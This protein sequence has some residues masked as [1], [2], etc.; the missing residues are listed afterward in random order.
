MD[1]Q[2][3]QDDLKL[4]MT[5]CSDKEHLHAW[6][7]Y[8]LGLDF[9]DC[10]VSRFSDSNPMQFIWD[11]YDAIINGKPLGVMA[12]AGRDSFKTLGLSAIDLLAFL[13]DGRD[14]IHLAMT[15]AQGMRARSYLEEA[16]S[17][18]PA[19]QAAI[20]KQNESQLRFNIDGN[21]VGMEI[22]PCT[23]KA[24]QGGHCSLLTFDELASSMD[25]TNLRGYKDAHGIVGTSRKGQPAVVIKI[26]SRQTGSSLAEQELKN[27]SKS[28]LQIK[29]WTSLDATQRCEDE[30]SG[31]V[32]T[33]LWIDMK[34]GQVLSQA[35]YDQLPL[36]RKA[37]Y[38]ITTD[39]YDKCRTC[40]LA[41][42]CQGD[43]KKQTSKST[44]LRKIDDVITKIR[45]NGN[46]DWIMAQIMS[47]EPSK[48]GMVFWEYDPAI[49]VPGWNKMWEALTGHVPTQPVTRDQFVAEL[50][51][52]GAQFYAGQD[53]GWTHPACTVIIAVDRRENVYVIDAVYKVRHSEP[54]IAEMVAREYMPKYNFHMVAPDVESP[55]G[56]HEMKKRGIPVPQQQAK[57]DIKK[58]VSLIKGFLRVPGTNDQTK[59]Y[60]APDLDNSKVPNVEGLLEEMNLYHL[61]EDAAGNVLDEPADKYNHGIDALGYIMEWLFGKSRAL[62]AMSDPV[63]ETVGAIV[64]DMTNIAKQQGIVFNDNR[65]EY[66]ELQGPI[67]KVPGSGDDDDDPNQGGGSPGG[68]QWSWT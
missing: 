32:R 66:A 47:L 60:F 15:K 45:L 8:F 37:G 62:L 23:P 3:Q 39:T 14:C 6:L 13:H 50:K 33:P 5:P 34:R 64:P 21:L 30:R 22:L 59:L 65:D 41:A 24:V 38:R 16:I 58:R 31:T 56:I 48:Q 42:Y 49:N 2:N 35:E 27:A 44:V 68:F 9:P 12:L 52:R 61:E 11:C 7:D 57:K 1:N 4:L 43:L 19:L 36:E 54:E 10:T 67:G 18:N 28:G 63:G 17:K 25:P 55:G 29:R 40:P 46:H 26:T 20:V 53:W 51:K